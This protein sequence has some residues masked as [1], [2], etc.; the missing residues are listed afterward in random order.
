MSV[1]ATELRLFVRC[2]TALLRT[3]TL[4]TEGTGDGCEDG[5]NY[6]NDFLDV[7]LT[8]DDD[9]LVMND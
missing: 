2:Y 8:H 4:Y 9:G 3:A 1:Y 6:V 5:D 7:F